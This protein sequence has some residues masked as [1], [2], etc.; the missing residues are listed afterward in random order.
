MNDM[1]KEQVFLA[2]EEI[3][4]AYSLWKKHSLNE[5]IDVIREIKEKLIQ[6]TDL[7]ARIITEEMN[8]PISQ[9]VAEVKKCAYLCEYY[10]ENAEKFLSPQTFKT[11]WTESVVVFE[12]L[13]VLLGVMP[14]NFPF[15]QVFRFVI[16]NLIL[17]NL[18]VVK[19]ASNVPKSAQM[20]ESVFSSQKTS[21]PL[22]KN[23]PIEANVVAEVIGHKHIRGVSLTGSEA[24]GKS[25]AQ[26]AG[27][28]LK[29]SVLELGGSA[30]FIVC[31]DADLEL[32]TSLGVDARMRNAGQSCIS[33]KRF[34][35]HESLKDIFINSYRAKTEALRRGDK[36]SYDTE[37]S[38]MAREDLAIELDHM[39]QESIA[40]GATL[41]CGG[42]RKGA[43]YEPTILCDVTPSMPVFQQE[44]FGPV[45]VISTFKTFDQAVELS[46]Q[47]DFGLGVSIF[48]K[49]TDFIKSQVHRFDEGA[50]YI[51]EMLISD[52]YLPFGGVKNSG[53]GRE[54]SQFGLYEFANIKTIVV[55]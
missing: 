8:K 11:K 29:K 9:S 48:S 40:Q 52:P 39:V 42:K 21:F 2:I 32:A 18:V 28:Y 6:D 25:V 4:N 16:P 5:R 15:W 43:F 44:T 19:H 41:I 34:L 55:R 47:S 36:F 38:E 45:A 1:N 50:V 10:S 12:P 13:G 22:Y 7:Y 53:Y 54:L 31:E 30:A 33:A 17:G 23:L 46:N 20:L 35:V 27:H 3:Q 26:C 37:I 51:N 14:W 24:A 49:N